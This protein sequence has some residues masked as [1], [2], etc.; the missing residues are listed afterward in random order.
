MMD[1]P[2]EGGSRLRSSPVSGVSCVLRRRRRRSKNR[3][4]LMPGAASAGSSGACFHIYEHSESFI[5]AVFGRS[6]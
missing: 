4:P 5:W 2:V 3:S 1:E 6:G